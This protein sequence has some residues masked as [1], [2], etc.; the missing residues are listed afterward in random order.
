[1]ID[2]SILTPG[3]VVKVIDSVPEGK[4]WNE[5]AKSQ[6]GKEVTIR[7]CENHWGEFRIS[8]E[9][10]AIQWRL[11]ELEELPT[12]ITHDSCQLASFLSA[13]CPV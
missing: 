3:L 1:M 2:K 7:K 4:R 13:F 6:L 11:E 8:V 12:L 10:N 5:Y 9:E